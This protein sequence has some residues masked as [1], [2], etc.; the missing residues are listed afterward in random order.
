MM[1]GLLPIRTWEASSAKVVS[2]T[3]CRPF[4]IAGVAADEVGQPGGAGRRVGQAGDRVHG[5]GGAAAAAA[6]VA[7]LAGDLEDLA[8]VREVREPAHADR[9]EGADLRP[10]VGEGAGA[11]QFRDVLPGQPLAAPQ[12]RGLVGLDDQQVVR[13]LDLD[14][15]IGVLAVGVQ[16]VRG[17]HRTGQVHRRKQRGEPWD[18]AGGAVDLA[19]GQHPAA[20]VLHGRGAGAPAGRR[21]LSPA[22]SCRRPRPPVAAGGN[23]PGGRPAT[24]R[25]PWSGPRRPTAPGFGGWWSRMAPSSGRG[26]RGGRQVPRG[27]AGGYR[28]P[29]RRSRPGSGRW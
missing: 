17:D 1:C 29:T 18:L 6:P 23:L 19:L 2:R 28:R 12:Q 27:P 10:A 9:L 21:R 3:W 24:R 13:L 15:P 7:D 5:L 4:S 26:P 16:R 11:V 14:Q 25:P 22:A 20:G 8:D